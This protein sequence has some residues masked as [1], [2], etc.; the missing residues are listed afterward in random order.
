MATL[1]LLRHGDVPGI[2]PP[3]F[4]GRQELELTDR[5]REQAQR[6]A[7]RLHAGWP[8]IAAIHCSPRHR[9]VATAEAVGRAYG[10]IPQ[11][12]PEFDDLDYGTWHGLTHDEA[13]QRWPEQWA[14]WTSAPEEVTFPQ[15]E[16][17]AD[18]SARV[19]R[20][21]RKVVDGA[22]PHAV[23]VVVG[24]DSTN[25]ILLMQLLGMH[26][27]FYRMLAQDPC[28]LNVIESPGAN[29]LVRLLNSTEH[30]RGL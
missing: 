6:T 20:G 29:A 8:Q 10:L 9:T 14:L 3:K 27:R 28:C 30:L 19:W 13:R 2:S 26:L 18:L 1:L 7:E 15:G 4:R 5:G 22:R 11:P 17:L 21:L 23:V 16:N 25:R 24:H 12:L